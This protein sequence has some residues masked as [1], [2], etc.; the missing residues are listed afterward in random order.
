MLY[1]V[2]I[3]TSTLEICDSR[4]VKM[5]T[6]LKPWGGKDGISPFKIIHVE[7]EQGQQKEIY[8][9]VVFKFTEDK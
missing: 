9:G 8:P 5:V 7:I 1:E 3:N 2:Q 4:P 6:S